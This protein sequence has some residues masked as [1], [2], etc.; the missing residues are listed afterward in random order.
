MS[1]EWPAWFVYNLPDGLWVYG[2]TS[3]ML[4]IWNGTLEKANSIWVFLPVILA[5][6]SEFGQLFGVVPGT[7]DYFD[8]VFM[9]L[10]QLISL[11]KHSNLK[12]TN[13][14]NLQTS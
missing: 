2:Y 8:I 1:F 12:T 14:E 9:L 4:M 6:I 3:I 10:A 5:V 11:Y 13:H 7:F